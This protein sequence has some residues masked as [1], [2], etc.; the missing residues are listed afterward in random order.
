MKM[1]IKIDTLIIFY[2]RI[3]P[4]ETI[5][6]DSDYVKKN[7]YIFI[8]NV[9]IILSSSI[10]ILSINTKIVEMI[11]ILSPI[12]IDA[13]IVCIPEFL[14]ICDNHAQNYYFP[15]KP[16]KWMTKP[17]GS[18]K[19]WKSQF[20]GVL[21]KIEYLLK[22]RTSYISRYRYYHFHLSCLRLFRSQ[23]WKNTRKIYN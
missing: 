7:T 2:V 3:R 10:I 1:F 20:P 21:S 6:D 19:T 4:L 5:F 18:I 23:V 15:K 11:P 22:N 17:R 16:T 14:F 12:C 9:K 13:N 8:L